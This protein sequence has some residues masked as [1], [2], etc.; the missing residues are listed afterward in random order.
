M[1]R[2]S[3]PKV[4]ATDCD[5]TLLRSD[6]TISPR[7]QAAVEAAEAAGI[8]II[9]VTARPPRWLDELASVAGEHAIALCGNGA[10]TYD[11]SSRE[12]ISHRLMDPDLVVQLAAELHEAIPDIDL[13]LES[14]AGFAHE[15]G[16]E[17]MSGRTDGFWAVGPVAELVAS[18]PG[19]LLVRMPSADVDEL[20]AQVEHV[21]A[22]RAEVSHSGAAG[23]AEIV[24]TGVTK[25]MAIQ[26]WCEEHSVEAADVWTFGDM[27]NDI[28]MLTWA[29]RSFAMANGH[30]QA[31]AAAT[32]HIASND[33]DGVA[34]VLEQALASAL[35][36]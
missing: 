22:G 20:F 6:G 14:V 10:F 35:R 28:P 15:P 18:P 17:R 4:I 31:K 7:T 13:A 8:T 33:E 19:K 3:L 25:G 5:G 1:S 32:D 9:L 27:P 11:L 2:P 26:A 29:G 24:A 21:V 23:M 12:I 36:N 30:E 16:F 34:E